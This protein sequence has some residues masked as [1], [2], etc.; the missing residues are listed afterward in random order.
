MS[1]SH[2]EQVGR[3]EETRR[4]EARQG[5]DLP[6]HTDGG[7]GYHRL[8][9][10][11]PATDAAET[12]HAEINSAG[13]EGCREVGPL[14]VHRR[15][16]G[17]SWQCGA[18]G[19]V[20]SHAP[21]DPD[22]AEFTAALRELADFIDA[23]PDLPLPRGVEVSPYLNGTD[24][25]DRAEVDRIGGIL[26]TQPRQSSTGQYRVRRTFGGRATY[27]AVAIPERQMQ[28]WAALMSYG[29]AVTQ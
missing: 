20:W 9:R 19:K 26:S 22:R 27:E 8:D 25:E 14:L 3:H 17:R 28:D 21:A 13:C 2:A 29:D 5:P 12:P 10:M 11:A 16:H 23:H 18:C 24:E 4:S 15:G 1:P 7:T 6:V